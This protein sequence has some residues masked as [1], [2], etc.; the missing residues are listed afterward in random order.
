MNN[1]HVEKT[2]EQRRAALKNLAAQFGYAAIAKIAK[3]IDVDAS[4]LSR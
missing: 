3:E 2:Y 1:G 4:Y